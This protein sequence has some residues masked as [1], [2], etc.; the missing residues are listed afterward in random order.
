MA[1]LAAVDR[2]AAAGVAVLDVGCGSGVL[3]VAAAVL[4]A[5]P[6]V[7]VDVDPVAVAA[8]EANADANGVEIDVSLGSAGEI[9]GRFDLVLANVG[10]GTVIGMAATLAARTAPGGRVVTAGFYADRAGEVSAALSSHGLV[11]VDRSVDAGW[12]S[13]I[14]QSP[15]P[16]KHT[17]RASHR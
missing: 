5:G 14:H 7:A 13:L 8:T 12:A 10:A 11:E 3:A 15:S 16:V 1:G 2:W 9:D 4:G 6:V 17:V